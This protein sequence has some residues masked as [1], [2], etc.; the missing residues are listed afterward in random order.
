LVKTSAFFLRHSPASAEPPAERQAY[1]FIPFEDLTL[2][3]LLPKPRRTPREV[4][5]D[6]SAAAI[7]TE[8][9]TTARGNEPED[10][11][12]Q[13]VVEPDEDFDGNPSAGMLTVR[14]SNARAHQPGCHGSRST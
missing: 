7:Y 4:F 8:S 13:V 12:L 6:E 14:C 5:F 1:L 10:G 2:T 9:E 3:S 11:Q